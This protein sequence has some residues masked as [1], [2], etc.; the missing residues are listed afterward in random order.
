[1]LVWNLLAWSR[2]FTFGLA[3]RELCPWLCYCPMEP[4]R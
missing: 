4:F 3:Q 2:R 1:M